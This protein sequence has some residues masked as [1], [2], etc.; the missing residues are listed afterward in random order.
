VSP[1]FVTAA[2]REMLVV[3]LLLSTPLLLAAILA[4]IIV[5]V[6]QAGTR[7]NDLTL[8]FV[9]RFVAVLLALYFTASWTLTEMIDYFERSAMA[10]RAFAG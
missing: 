1:E 10:I 9:P 7:I 8:S 6:F 4:G 2:A 5:G 3:V